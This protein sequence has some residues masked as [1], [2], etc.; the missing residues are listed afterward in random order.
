MGSVT[1]DLVPIPIFTLKILQPKRPKSKLQSFLHYINLQYNLLLVIVCYFI[2]YNFDIPAAIT[3]AAAFIHLGLWL[4][5][6]IIV[7]GFRL[8][9]Y[10][11]RYW[12]ICRLFM[13]F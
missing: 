2:R 9:I 3:A 4:F 11:L 1:L 5:Q 6:E 10:V 13:T 7:G 12:D 8:K